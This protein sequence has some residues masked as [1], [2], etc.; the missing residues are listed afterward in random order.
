MATVL[1]VDDERS[2][3]DL[4]VEIVEESG[5]TALRAYNGAEALVLAKRYL[6]ELIISDVM[7]PGMDGYG[8]VQAVRADATLTHTIIVL[9]SAVFSQRTIPTGTMTA[10]LPKPL[11]L[12][13]LDQLLA[14]LP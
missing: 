2:I 5:H 11:D 8:L 1:V 10:F 7:M 12:V 3:T 6:P 4:L 14:G 9:I 13:V